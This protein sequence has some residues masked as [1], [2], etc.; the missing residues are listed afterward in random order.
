MLSDIRDL[1]LDARRAA[2]ARA[3]SELA[4]AAVVQQQQA[5]IVRIDQAARRAQNIDV[6]RHL[7][8]QFLRESRVRAVTTIE[9][10]D[11]FPGAST[12]AAWQVVEPAYV[13]MQTGR[14]IQPG[15]AVPMTHGEETDGEDLT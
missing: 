11:Q 9:S 6:L 1:L 12:D 13:D 2:D 15:R 5:M 4:V 8:G 3:T 14:L 7:V 10:I